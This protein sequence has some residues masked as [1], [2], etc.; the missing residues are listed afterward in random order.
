MDSGTDHRADDGRGN[1]CTVLVVS[2]PD[3]HVSAVT[4]SDG[5]ERFIGRYARLPGF[6]QRGMLL[7]LRP[8]AESRPLDRG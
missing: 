2:S 4:M 5:M 1:R 8:V 3:G 7:D 6:G